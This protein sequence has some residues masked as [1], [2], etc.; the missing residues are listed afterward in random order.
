LLSSVDCGTG[1]RIH[2]A[3]KGAGI[4]LVLYKKLL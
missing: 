2:P 1:C 4:L 3:P